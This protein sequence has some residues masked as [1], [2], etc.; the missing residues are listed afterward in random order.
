M[1][2]S[3]PGR[4][5]GIG[6]WPGVDVVEAV[7]T[8]FGELPEPHVPYLP[9]LPG[10]GPGA[11]MIGRAAALL[12]D[13]PV[14]LQ[15]VG[16]RLVDRPGRDLGRAQAWL[17]QDLD[18]LAELAEGYAGPLK[19]QCTGPWTLA[20]G[21]HLP[22]L[23]RAVV[24]AGASRDLAGS[25]AEGLAQHVGEVRRLV[26]GAEVVVQLDEP[27]LP[28]VLAGALPTASGFGRLRAVDEPVVVDT[29]AAVLEGV[30]EAGAV[31]TVLHCCADA[32]P[33]D[34]LARA[35][36]DGLSLDVSR[37]GRAEWEALG[38]VIEGRTA[39]W[40]GIVPTSGTLITTPAAADV[41]WDPWRRLGLDV[42]LLEGV[43]VTPACGLAATTPADARARLARAKDVADA[44]AQ[45]AAE[46]R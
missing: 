15:P 5:S 24:D 27:S 31:A 14:D 33:V 37:L 6:S 34:V 43:V 40:A 39:L 16:W 17:R 7:R 30:R 11:D 35:G 41:V 18:V 29:L 19:L 13:L 46:D 10:R 28:A 32:P 45:R 44:L 23:E 3:V 8:T 4:A 1:L 36:A 22:R 9:E 20:A 42:G 2:E 25:L 26:P 21:L 12:V 38:T